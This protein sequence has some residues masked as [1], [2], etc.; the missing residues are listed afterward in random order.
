MHSVMSNRSP[1]RLIEAPTPADFWMT[2][3]SRPCSGDVITEPT[4]AIPRHLTS[5]QLAAQLGVCV[6]VVERWR[7]RGD[8]PLFVRIGRTIRYSVAAVEQW[9]AQNTAGT[10]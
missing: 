8:G 1:S 6:E 9:L 10:R 4:T 3:R 5:A 7:S 2:A